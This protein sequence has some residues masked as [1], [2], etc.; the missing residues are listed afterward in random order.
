[1]GV[2][3]AKP[4]AGV[5]GVPASF[6]F[7]KKC[8]DSALCNNSRYDNRFVGGSIPYTVPEMGVTF[9]TDKSDQPCYN[10]TCEDTE[11]SIGRKAIR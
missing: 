2:Q 4:P 7:P 8:V 10:S 3:G 1:M 9:V 6:P 5:R 11:A